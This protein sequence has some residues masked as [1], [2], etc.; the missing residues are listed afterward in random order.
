[1]I[2]DGILQF[3]VHL[4][5]QDILCLL[6]ALVADMACNAGNQYIGFTFIAAAERAFYFFRCFHVGD[7][8]STKKLPEQIFLK[9]KLLK[10]VLKGKEFVSIAFRKQVI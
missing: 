7:F 4:I 3:A 8:V 5:I 2:T 1:M 6:N 9:R 10:L